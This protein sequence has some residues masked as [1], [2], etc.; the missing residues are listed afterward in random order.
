MNNSMI[1]VSAA[2]LSWMKAQLSPGETMDDMFSRWAGIEKPL[3]VRPRSI[4]YRKKYPYHDMEPGEEILTAW[5]RDP[6]SGDVMMH[7]HNASISRC[8]RLPGRKYR[9][10]PTPRG[11]HV[12]RIT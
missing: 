6:K 9:V 1:R 2:V 3:I 5:I 4:D 11:L 10:T 7:G 12:L 8:N